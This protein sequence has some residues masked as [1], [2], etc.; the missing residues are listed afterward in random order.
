M[1]IK[2]NLDVVGPEQCSQR[3]GDPTPIMNE[4]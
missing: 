2:Q 3:T 4:T 1:G